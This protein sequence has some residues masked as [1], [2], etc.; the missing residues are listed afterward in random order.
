MFFLKILKGRNS[1][2]YLGNTTFL[3]TLLTNLGLCTGVMITMILKSIVSNFIW[4]YVSA[5]RNFLNWIIYRDITPPDSLLARPSSVRHSFCI[6]V[7][8]GAK[9]GLEVLHHMRPLPT[10][11]CDLVLCPGRLFGPCLSATQTQGR[12]ENHSQCLR[13]AASEWYL[14]LLF[15]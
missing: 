14:H 5:R 10:A 4:C 1:A 15:K 8:R 13:N 9:N 7:K 11:A 3:K 6:C 2:R 12:N